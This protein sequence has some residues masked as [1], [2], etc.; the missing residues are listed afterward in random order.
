MKLPYQLNARFENKP[1]GQDK[2]SPWGSATEIKNKW[3]KTPMSSR[4][5]R[6]FEAVEKIEK[7]NN[8]LLTAM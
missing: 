3:R 2:T 6:C 4:S 8:G 5:S 7:P 1:S